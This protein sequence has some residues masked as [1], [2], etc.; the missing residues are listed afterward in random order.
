MARAVKKGDGPRGD[1]EDPV[2]GRIPRIPWKITDLEVL[3]E[4]RVYP[5]PASGARTA[6]A[7]PKIRI[8]AGR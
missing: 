7:A 5:T 2:F 4:Q 8:P 1:T 6:A 3:E